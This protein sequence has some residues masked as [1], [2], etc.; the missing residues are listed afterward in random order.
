MHRRACPHLGLDAK[1]P[2]V[3]PSPPWQ[4]DPS[5][6]SLSLSSDMSGEGPHSPVTHRHPSLLSSV[7]PEG[8]ARSLHVTPALQDGNRGQIRPQGS[9][10][11]RT[12]HR[13]RGWGGR[14]E[15]VGGGTLGGW[16]GRAPAV[17]FSLPRPEG[18]TPRTL[19]PELVHR[20]AGASE[21]LGNGVL[22]LVGVERTGHS[23]D[24]RSCHTGV[25]RFHKN[26]MMG[27]GSGLPGHSLHDLGPPAAGSPAWSL[28]RS[29]APAIATVT[30]GAQGTGLSL[31]PDHWAVDRGAK[32]PAVPAAPP[33]AG[34]S[35]TITD[36]DPTRRRAVGC[37]PGLRFISLGG[38]GKVGGRG[39]TQSPRGYC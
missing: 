39:G 30:G 27:A 3:I 11:P 4:E 15:R 1:V 2:W 25:V 5:S 22:F 34:P 20:E 38:A 8:N 7:A 33:S 32:E 36:R 23:T 9:L 26:T 14:V 16:H 37:R 17:P 19:K 6:W 24:G 13:G 31:P 29:A 21:P 12:R 35:R 28:T 10:D 18:G